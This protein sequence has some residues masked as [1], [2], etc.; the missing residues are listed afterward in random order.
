MESGAA[1]V[2]A[3]KRLVVRIDVRMFVCPSLNADEPRSG[4]AN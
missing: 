3:Y 1:V 4:Y 2:R